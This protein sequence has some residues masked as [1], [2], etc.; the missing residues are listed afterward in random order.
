MKN[1][2]LEQHWEKV[3]LG[4]LFC[5]HSVI[6]RRLWE[7]PG[8]WFLAGSC[9]NTQC[10]SQHSGGDLAEEQA[11]MGQNQA[12][13]VFEFEGFL[14]PQTWRTELLS[15]P[16][17]CTQKT[18]HNC[19]LKQHHS[20]KSCMPTYRTIHPQKQDIFSAPRLPTLVDSHLAS[21]SSVTDPLSTL[22]SST[23]D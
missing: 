22:Q 15:C 13:K 2:V 21:D 17:S 3:Q 23:L 11:A 14:P 1:S 16:L 18:F 7:V 8:S 12:Q 20:S 6:N 10:N 19:I 9:Q 4:V 5:S